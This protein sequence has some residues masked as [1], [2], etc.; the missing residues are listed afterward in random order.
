MKYGIFLILI[1]LVVMSSL[2]G[3]VY[4]RSEI[5]T[6]PETAQHETCLNHDNCNLPPLKQYTSGISYDDIQCK[7]GFELVGKMPYAD[8]ACVKPESLEKLVMR[9]WATADKTL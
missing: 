2:T 1:G 5:I 3:T 4:G 8:P 6:I 7:D 9:G